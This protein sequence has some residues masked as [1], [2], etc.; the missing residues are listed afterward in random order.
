MNP[1]TPYLTYI[2]I[3]AIVLVIVVFAWQRNTIA[4]QREKIGLYKQAQ[5]SW[6]SVQD[7]NLGNVAALKSRIDNMVAER[8]ADKAASNLAVSLLAKKDAA[9]AAK[10]S[11]T[12]KELSNVYA[13]R[14]SARAWGAIGVD[15]S[16]ADRLPKRTATR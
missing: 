10:L 11:E 13:K 9:T 7:V 16:V 6:Q 4:D 3:G 1:L 5:V 8:E 2:K 15:A 12:E 14:P